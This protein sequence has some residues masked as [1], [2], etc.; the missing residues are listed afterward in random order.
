ML[1]V[2][3]NSYAAKDTICV[4]FLTKMTQ[5]YRHRNY[6]SGW[7]EFKVKVRAPPIKNGSSELSCFSF[8]VRKIQ[9]RFKHFK[10]SRSFNVVWILTFR[11]VFANN[12]VLNLHFMKIKT[13]NDNNFEY[14]KKYD[15]VGID[16]MKEIYVPRLLQYTRKVHCVYL[17]T[18]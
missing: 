18:S 8:E 13:E 11:S 3:L 15:C 17:I 10:L 14:E 5:N 12:L 9:L 16:L 1:K 7:Q 6:C 2:S 4:L